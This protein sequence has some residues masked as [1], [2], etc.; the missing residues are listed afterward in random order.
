MSTIWT[1]QNKGDKSFFIAEINDREKMRKTLNKYITAHDY[2]NRILFVLSGKSSRVSLYSFTTAN[3]TPI[4]VASASISLL[5]LT[6]NGIFKM[7][8][9]A[10]TK[11]KKNKSEKNALLYRS[12]LIST[13][14][15]I[16]ILDWKKASE[17]KRIS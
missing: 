16:S 15:I 5:F 6:S 3:G 2:A 14:K 13:E 9:K 17:Q 11:K 7:L 8:F 10:M 4:G 12:N 1:Q